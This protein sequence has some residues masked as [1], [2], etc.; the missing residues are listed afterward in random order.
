MSGLLSPWVK[1]LRLTRASSY[2]QDCRSLL[3]VGCGFGEL[4]NYIP[5]EVDYL[6]VDISLQYI[7]R[8]KAHF[9]TK[10]FLV[11]DIM[12]NPLPPG[13]YDG[14]SCLAVLEHLSHPDRLLEK[15]YPLI[16]PGGVLVIS[17]PDPKGGR[18]HKI[19]ASLYLLSPL[20]RDEH[21]S[22][23]DP[24]EVIAM[25]GKRG[26]HPIHHEPFLFS[27]NHLFVAYKP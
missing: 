14:V 3:D 6:G 4:L 5:L 7:A 2:L 18:W 19:L 17:T 10:T 25:L 9:P 13:P 8:A 20:A 26:F 1:K 21:E 12:K 27:F 23:L 24:Q 22:F 15:V 11:L 16:N